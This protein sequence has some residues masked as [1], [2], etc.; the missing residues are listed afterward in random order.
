MKI[1]SVLTGS[2]MIMFLLCCCKKLSQSGGL[3]EVVCERSNLFS[4]GEES[5]RW[6]V[7]NPG[8][9]ASTE[10]SANVTNVKEP[11]VFTHSRCKIA[12]WSVYIF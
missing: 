10:G 9:I 1:S 7:K 11:L 12:T 2:E 5:R 6:L 3:K 4:V 8:T